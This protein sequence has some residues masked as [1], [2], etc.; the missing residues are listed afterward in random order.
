M[1]VLTRK[2][3]EQICIPQCGLTVKVVAIQGGG[4]RLAFDA[5]SELGIYREEVWERIRAERPARRPPAR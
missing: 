5:P 2:V 4:V 1:L 3:G